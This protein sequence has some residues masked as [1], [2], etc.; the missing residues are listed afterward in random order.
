[1]PRRLERALRLV[2]AYGGLVQA[3]RWH[4]LHWKLYGAPASPHLWSY[5]ANKS[6]EPQNLGLVSITDLRELERRGIVVADSGGS[7]PWWFGF[8]PTTFSL[9]RETP[10]KER[11]GSRLTIRDTP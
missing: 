9:V 11:A 6:V 5:G 7:G 10:R 4:P 1:M 2:K 3:R 8:A